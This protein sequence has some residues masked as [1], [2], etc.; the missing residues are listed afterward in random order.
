MTEM[1]FN[2]PFI[3]L[4]IYSEVLFCTNSVGDIL[5]RSLKHFEKYEGLE[6]PVS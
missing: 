3:E 6:N 1:S 4:N 2:Y 5:Y